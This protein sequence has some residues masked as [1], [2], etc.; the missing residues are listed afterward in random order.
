MSS[1]V[2][3]TRFP[4]PGKLNDFD[5]DQPTGSIDY[6][7][8]HRQKEKKESADAKGFVYNTGDIGANYK[9]LEPNPIKVYLAIPA[10]INT[11]Y[12]ATYKVT[13]LGSV[14]LA[15]AQ[16]LAGGSSESAIAA[17]TGLAEKGSPEMALN[18]LNS[19]IGAVSSAIG[20]QYDGDRNSMLA[21]SQGKIFNPYQENLFTGTSFRAHQFSF[22]MIARNESEATIIG[23]IINYL[24]QGMLPSFSGANASAEG[25]G[26]L[27]G[28]TSTAA[29]RFLV[30]PN[31]F[32]LGFFRLKEDGTELSEVAH[33]RFNMCVLKSID[34]NYT[35]DGQYVSFKNVKTNKGA[36]P[37]M[38]PAVEMSLQ[39]EEVS[40]VTAEQAGSG[41]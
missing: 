24:K 35:P 31:K 22:K 33:Y 30:V 9:G 18:T 6:L 10:R 23:R 29:G 19:A 20:S 40:Y 25:V 15:A 21:I 41:Y 12:S 36:N 37:L 7:M 5:R 4:V 26:G 28:E 3:P 39:F 2:Y 13:T 17:L 32:K 16:A 1:L 11:N 27:I 14:G 38:V 8:I 34:V